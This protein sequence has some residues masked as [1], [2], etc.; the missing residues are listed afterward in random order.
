MKPMYA[1]LAAMECRK[2]GATGVWSASRSI[3]VMATCRENAVQTREFRQ[4]FDE[5]HEEGLETRFPI[6]SY[7]PPEKDEL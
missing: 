5:L 1:F 7:I 6:V 4:L 2:A 3:V